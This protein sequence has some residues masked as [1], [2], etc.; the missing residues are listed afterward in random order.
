M[1]EADHHSSSE[2]VGNT[3]STTD[4]FP[5]DVR[6]NHREAGIRVPGQ[7]EP[8]RGETGDCAARDKEGPRNVG[9]ER[10][11][12]ASMTFSATSCVHAEEEHVQNEGG[13]TKNV[14]DIDGNQ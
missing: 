8:G 14:E 10:N 1:E 3:S 4:M 12:S 7:V 11:S 2:R 9:Q 13:D 5:V 6:G